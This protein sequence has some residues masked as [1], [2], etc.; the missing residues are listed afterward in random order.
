MEEDLSKL[1]QSLAEAEARNLFLSSEL[2]QV[3][4]SRMPLEGSDEVNEQL[5]NL[6]TP[7]SIIQAIPGA[8]GSSSCLPCVTQRGGRRKD[9]KLAVQ[10]VWGGSQSVLRVA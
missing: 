5:Y 6:P 10:T 8:A 2:A 4:D 7:I 3:K 9:C 1:R